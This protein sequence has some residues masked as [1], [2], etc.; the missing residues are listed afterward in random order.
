MAA[1]VPKLR[2]RISAGEPSRT[3]HSTRPAEA[4]GARGKLTL[5]TTAVKKTPREQARQQP[6]P[7][8]HP[9]EMYAQAMVH[10]QA[11]WGIGGSV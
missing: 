4:L 1:I 11:A 10:A 6:A 9:A 7:P 3:H 8:G 2:Q 5:V